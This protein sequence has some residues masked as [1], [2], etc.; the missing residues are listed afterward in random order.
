MEEANKKSFRNV[1]RRYG[2]TLDTVNA[3]RSSKNQAARKVR[4]RKVKRKK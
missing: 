3:S 4:K 2:A 1:T